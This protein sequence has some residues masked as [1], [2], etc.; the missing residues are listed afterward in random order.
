MLRVAV[1]GMRG[2]GTTHAT[3]YAGDSLAELVACCD[4][5]KERA[6]STAQRFGARPYYSVQELLAREKLD[7]VSVATGGFENGG[8]HYAPVM[9]CL[10]AGLHV[11]CE[12]PLS[13]NI[14]QAR[15][16]ARTAREKGLYLG[17]NLN[18]RFVPPAAKALEWIRNGDLG[19]LLFINMA[20]WI[21]NPNE[22]S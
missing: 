19:D 7:A 9:E 18:H 4:V 6:D 16:M 1:I 20:L 22:T 10:N 15:E 8:D 11:L 12:K 2:I 3:C 5:V 17:V 13:N 21:N 14:E